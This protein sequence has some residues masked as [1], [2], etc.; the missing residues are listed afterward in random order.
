[1]TEQQQ[2]AETPTT[3]QTQQ[4]RGADGKFLPKPKPVSQP[5]ETVRE[6][7]EKTDTFSSILTEHRDLLKERAAERG[8]KVPEGFEEESLRSQIK[9][10]KYAARGLESATS[11]TTA[12][13]PK[14][15]PLD[16]TKTA[17][18]GGEV[19]APTETNTPTLLQLNRADKFIAEL[20]A[21]TGYR[22][23]RQGNTNK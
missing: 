16:K 6:P 11:D 4:G 1:M 5:Q 20:N 2:P 7:T 13:A 19:P 22:K 12:T 21:R 23:Y 8:W 18:I 9:I 3:E 17:S 14:A 15:Q 10:L